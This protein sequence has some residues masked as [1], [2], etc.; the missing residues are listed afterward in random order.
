MGVSTLAQPPPCRVGEVE[1]DDELHGLR[2]V[3]IVRGREHW[4]H[5]RRQLETVHHPRRRD[6]APQV[7]YLKGKL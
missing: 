5:R 2:R 4:L 1:R 3:G 6:V 7:V